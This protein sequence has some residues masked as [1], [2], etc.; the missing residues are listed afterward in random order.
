M[1]GSL[2]LPVVPVLVGTDASGLT[3]T[4]IYRYIPAHIHMQ[5]IIKTK[6]K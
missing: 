5:I 6:F 4:C 3:G 1:L 2:H